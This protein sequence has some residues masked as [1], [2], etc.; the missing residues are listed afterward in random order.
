MLYVLAVLLPPVATWLAGKRLQA[1]LI[2]L[3][4]TILMWLP[5]VVHAGLVVYAT[6]VQRHVDAQAARRVEDVRPA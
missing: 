6:R 2:T 1:I 4:L 3:P 5:G